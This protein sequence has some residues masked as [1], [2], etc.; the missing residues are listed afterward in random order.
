[1]PEKFRLSLKNKLY[2]GYVVW[3]EMVTLILK[4]KLLGWKSIQMP[5]LFLTVHAKIIQWNNELKYANN[6]NLNFVMDKIS[7]AFSSGCSPVDF[8]PKSST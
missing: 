7:I 4:K 3:V 2:T 5:Q 8:L 1:M 6:I